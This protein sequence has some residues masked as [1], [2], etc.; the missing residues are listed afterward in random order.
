VQAPQSTGQVEHISFPLHS[1]SPQYWTLP[2][3]AAAMLDED[4]ATSDDD[5]TPPEDKTAV[6]DETIPPDEAGEIPDEE[7]MV[8]DDPD[9]LDEERTETDEEAWAPLKDTLELEPDA[10][11]P[12][13]DDDEEEDEP[14]SAGGQPVNTMHNATTPISTS[15]MLRMLALLD[16]SSLR[17]GGDKSQSRSC[18]C[19]W[20]ETS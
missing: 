14:A 10:T 18:K 1:R 2:E 15:R 6:P 16:Q 9:G 4:T 17:E 13:D 8:P 11:P 3:D 20:R 19:T 12:V 7:Q 5:A